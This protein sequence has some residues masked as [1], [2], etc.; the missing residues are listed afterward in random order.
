[1][2]SLPDGNELTAP[3]RS[4]KKSSFITARVSFKDSGFLESPDSKFETN[5]DECVIEVEART[6]KG[7]QG[8]SNVS[9]VH[10]Y[11]YQNTQPSTITNDL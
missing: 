10:L 4:Q 1:M 5:I 2:F 7:D 11:F 9:I 3:S 6:Q 8:L